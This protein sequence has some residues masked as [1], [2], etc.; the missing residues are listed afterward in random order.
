MSTAE[1]EGLPL[2]IDPFARNRER[3]QSL[4]R[5]LAALVLATPK[6]SAEQILRNEWPRDV[7]AG[8][9]VRAAVTQATT[10]N[11][12]LPSVTKIDLLPEVAPMS[13]A[14]RLFANCLRVN[15]DGVSKVAVPR[16]VPSKVPI[17]VGEGKP[18]PVIDLS[19]LDSM[20]G[21]TRKILVLSATTTELERAGPEAASAVIGRVIENSVTNNLDTPVFDD[22]AADDDRPAGLLWGLTP[23]AP[24]TNTGLIAIA[25]DL[26]NLAGEI[27]AND[28]V[29]DGMVIVTNS[30]Q[31]K[32]LE[33]LCPL[34]RNVFGS[35][36]VPVGRVIGIAPS[37]VGSGYSGVPVIDKSK[38]SAFHFEDTAPSDIG[39]AS[40]VAAPTKSAFQT[41][42]IAIKVR[43][44]AAWARIAPG[45]SFVDGVNW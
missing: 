31:A 37:A 41:D 32:R 36:R 35:P 6:R 43:C 29:T 16:S 9:I 5:A 21:P 1:P 33:V 34:L 14:V 30:A 27:A 28:V 7:S 26:G 23:L 44:Y 2:R 4:H 42:V 39:T 45:I 3:R 17:F 40:G 8:A 18:A 25:D 13:V 19:L 22:V 10:E 11:T 12:G 24:S 15:L 38:G 20:I